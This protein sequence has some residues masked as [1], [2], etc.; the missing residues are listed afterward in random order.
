MH[1]FKFYDDNEDRAG[2][3]GEEVNLVPVPLLRAHMN[4]FYNECR[5]FGKIAESDLNGKV[6]VKCYDYLTVSARRK[7]ELQRK[8]NVII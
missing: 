2:L 1:Q 8:F 3:F 5:A 4:P 7:K 6:A